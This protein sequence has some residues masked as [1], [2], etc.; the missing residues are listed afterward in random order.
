MSNYQ[1]QQ[2][3]FNTEKPTVAV[4]LFTEHF[5]LDE[6][7]WQCPI[8]LAGSDGHL[9]YLPLLFNLTPSKPL[10]YVQTLTLRASIKTFRMLTDR[11]NVVFY[12]AEENLKFFSDY[13]DIGAPVYCVK[14]DLA[15]IIG[16]YENGQLKRFTQAEA[17]ERIGYGSWQE[18][19][20]ML[21]SA[22]WVLHAWRWCI[23]NRQPK[24]NP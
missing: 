6:G 8:S 5:V 1:N 11:Y 14:E 4:G 2:Y 23:A 3:P 20:P 17:V 7:L 19:H 24:A 22:V 16:E 21:N 13:F 15:R 18:H 10:T 9:A 12:G